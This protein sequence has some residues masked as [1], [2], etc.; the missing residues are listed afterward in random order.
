MV[1]QIRPGALAQWVQEV[2]QYGEPVVL[3]VREPYELQIASVKPEGS[4]LRTIPMGVIPLRLSE[5]DPARPVACLCHH[6]GRSMQVAHFLK[7]RGFAHVAN[8]AG[9]IHAWS[10]EL[11]PAIARY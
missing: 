4:E 8:I 5:L 2:R 9:G 3:D 10:S 6:G 11:D 7:S 1:V